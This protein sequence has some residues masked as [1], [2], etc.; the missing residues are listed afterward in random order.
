MLVKSVLPKGLRLFVSLF[1]LGLALACNSSS[2][3]L[4]PA[5]NSALQLEEAY[6]VLEKGSG[7]SFD[8][9]GTFVFDNDNDFSAHYLVHQG[10]GI[11]GVAPS[12][13][14]D[15]EKVIAIHLGAKPSYAYSVNIETVEYNEFDEVINVSYYQVEDRAEVWPAAIAHPYVL[16]RIHDQDY[17]VQFNRLEDRSG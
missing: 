10:V 12:I 9:E 14:F 2:E 5:T 6:R 17:R 7:S 15:S 3:E 1:S 13:D 8:S 11:A 4:R 16:L